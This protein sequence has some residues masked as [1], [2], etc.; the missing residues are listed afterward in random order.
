[1]SHDTSVDPS[2]EETV[3]ALFGKVESVGILLDNILPIVQEDVCEYDPKV[4][5][6][7]SHVQ[8]D[9][10][11]KLQVEPCLSMELMKDDTYIV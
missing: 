4:R 2:K 8:M 3:T 1:M 5:Q 10:N 6:G 11:E 7:V 9:S